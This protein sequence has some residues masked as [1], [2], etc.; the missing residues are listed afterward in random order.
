LA[1]DDNSRFKRRIDRFFD[2]QARKKQ[3]AL[4]PDALAHKWDQLKREVTTRSQDGLARARK[5]LPA[6]VRDRLDHARDEESEPLEQQL[7]TAPIYTEPG[8]WARSFIKLTTDKPPITLGLMTV[9]MLV[10]LMGIGMTNI[11]GAMEVYLPHGSPEEA[12]L[13][14]VREDW[15]TDVV[16]IYVETPNAFD[17]NQK[18]NITQREILLEMDAIE[19]NL[20]IYGQNENDDGKVPSDRGEI[21]HIFFS[22]SISTIVKELNSSYNHAYDAMVENAEE[23]YLAEGGAEILAIREAAQLAKEFAELSGE[24]GHYRIPE[25]DEDI[26]A[27]VDDIPQSVLNKVVLDVNGDGTWDTSVMVFGITEDV[28]PPVVMDRVDELIRTRGELLGRDNGVTFCKMMQTGPVPVTQA[29]TER[30]F[31]EFWRVFPLGVVLCAIMMFVLHRKLRVVL[32]AGLPTLYGIFITYGLIG[33]SGIEVTPTIIALGPILMALGVAY[34]LHLTNRYLDEIGETPQI[35]MMQAMSTTGRAIVLSALTTMIGFGSLMITNLSPVFTVGLSLTGGIFIC[36]MTTFLMSPSIAVW[37][38]FEATKTE[39]EW[40]TVARLVTRYDKLVIIVGIV[41]MLFS[42]SLL[43]FL[44]TNIDYLEMVPDDEPTLTG[45]VKYSED[46]NAG[47]LGMV[48]G[49]GAFRNEYGSGSEDAV[50]NLDEIDLLISGNDQ[51]RD[52]F[53]DVTNVNAIGITDLMKTVKFQ[54]NST[55][56]VVLEV[57]IGDAVNWDMSFWELLHEDQIENNP[58][59]QKY[60]LNVFYDSLTTEAVSMLMDMQLT[61]EG[62]VPL[63]SKTLVYVDMPLM[64]IKGMEVAVEGINGVIYD[65]THGNIKVSVLTGVA[66]IGTSVNAQ[67]IDQQIITLGA[68]LVFVFFV[69]FATFRNWKIALLTTMPVIWVVALEP[70]TFVGLGQALSLVT[71][72]IGSIVIGIGIDFSIHI[73]QRV[74]EGGV[75][76]PSVQRALAHTAQPLAEATLVTLFG[77]TAAFA[78]AITALWW[79]VFIIMVLLVFS[80]F[81]AMLLLPAMYSAVVKAGGTLE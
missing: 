20:D 2:K 41:L 52:G 23:W 19:R 21:D 74:V 50:D 16:V 14:E 71:V 63:C 53:N 33:W 65:Y 1:S 60:L 76:G 11:N 67:L 8:A 27:L 25:T 80:L 57:I 70:L 32:I 68:S 3:E 24:V 49:R 22:L 31:D 58:R 40:N 54:A 51:G 59:L 79:F 28:D 42:F 78:I 39:R 69:L 35:R 15:S 45:I 4:D 9:I 43:P 81:S 12:L 36:L 48:V 47:A 7:S 44:E 30:S 17:T 62:W 46:F 13:L 29:I 38:K 77:L 61:E 5:A 34:G 75:N 18:I 6:K 37:T 72:M 26:K 10:S 56:L 73:T 55:V 64:D 66:A